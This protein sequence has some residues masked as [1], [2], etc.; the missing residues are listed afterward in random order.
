MPT[1]LTVNWA[2]Q[3]RQGNSGITCKS[4][5]NN[6]SHFVRSGY[7]PASFT[8]EKF[9]ITFS[10]WLIYNG[11][12]EGL[13]KILTFLGTSHTNTREPVAFG[14]NSRGKTAFTINSPIK[15]CT[16]IDMSNT[17]FFCVFSFPLLYKNRFG[18]AIHPWEIG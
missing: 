12:W 8:Q 11:S 4:C 16:L 2:Q 5:E 3:C 9:E 6:G 15:S 13:V 18:A 17:G 7:I 1:C 14:F 10:C